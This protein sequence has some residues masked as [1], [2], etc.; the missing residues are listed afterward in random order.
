MN[1]ALYLIL[2]FSSL[3]FSLYGTNDIVLKIKF[4]G[5]FYT[6]DNLNNIYLVNG[7]NIDKQNFITGKK[8]H[9][10]NAF[11]GNIAFLDVSDPFRI[12]A[13]YKDFN[14]VVIL[15]NTL[16]PIGNPVLLDD[17]DVYDC[18]AIC[19]SKNGGFWI[20][21]NNKFQLL[22]FDNNLQQKHKS[23]S[24]SNLFNSKKIENDMFFMK[25]NNNNVYISIPA[26]GILNF[27]KY[28][29]LIKIYPILNINILNILNNQIMYCKNNKIFTYDLENYNTNIKELAIN[30]KIKNCKIEQN[31]YFLQTENTIIIYR[32]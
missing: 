25:E 23:I 16:S 21:D 32:K 20:F 2:I 13:F 9:Y 12:L 28:G 3:T 27:D 15:D 19:T 5:D 10:N 24:I 22:Y 11:F 18:K 7:T 6:T 30:S 1:K 31:F 4:N 8:Y 26:V 17:I 14:Q 29:A